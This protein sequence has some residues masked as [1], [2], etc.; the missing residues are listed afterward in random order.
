MDSESINRGDTPEIDG[1]FERTI[2]L[3]ALGELDQTF[4]VYEKILAVEPHNIGALCG[5][6]QVKYMQGHE[7]EALEELDKVIAREPSSW[8]GYL[9]KG[10][11]LLHAQRLFEAAG[12]FEEAKSLAD[13]KDGKAYCDVMISSAKEDHVGVLSAY[14][15]M[16]EL[17]LDNP[18]A[19]IRAA[20]SQLEVGD[21][22][23]ACENGES[24][25]KLSPKS[26]TGFLLRGV[27]LLEKKEYKGAYDDL[28]NGIRLAAPNTTKEQLSVWHGWRSIASEG[29]QN[30]SAALNDLSKC[31]E[32]NPRDGMARFFL[33]RMKVIV[34][35]LEGAIQ[36]YTRSLNLQY[37]RKLCLNSRGRA[38]LTMNNIG[39]AKRDFEELREIDSEGIGG[40]LGLG[41][42]LREEGKYREAHEYVAEAIRKK[43]NSAEAYIE[44]ASLADAEGKP[45]ESKKY[46]RKSFFP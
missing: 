40:I 7:K 36:A 6:A 11:L 26:S 16:K 33:G 20:I 15:R 17:G 14:R 46:R 45:N 44:L 41:S 24:L 10:E 18:Q 9:A 3:L 39:D 32:L 4:V 8:W 30:Y 19:K 34:G 43:P 31:V 21:T 38:Y 1:L 13:R 12:L 5:K 35:D 25:I 23:N 42:C 27:G 37:D 22:E 2:T 28:T 29:M